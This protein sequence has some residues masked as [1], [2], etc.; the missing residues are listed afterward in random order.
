MQP[1]PQGVLHLRFRVSLTF[2]TVG[3]SE[4]AVLGLP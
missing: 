4:L 3:W 1:A 2:H